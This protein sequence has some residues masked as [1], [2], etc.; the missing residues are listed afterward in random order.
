MRLFEA[1]KSSVTV[2]EAAQCYGIAVRRGMCRCPFHSDKTPSAKADERFHCF[3]CG[4]DYSVIDFTANLFGIPPVDAAKKLAYDFGIPYDDA[5]NYR[6]TREEIIR[7]NEIRKQRKN[8]ERFDALVKRCFL[9]LLD[10]Y[11][12]MLEWRKKYAPKQ[13]ADK[14]HPLFVEALKNMSFAD[15]AMDVLTVGSAA[16][17]SDFIAEFGKGVLELEKRLFQFVEGEAG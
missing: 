15:Y 17:K 14:L 8:A 4:A 5:R 3:G 16:D 12:L 10:Y 6:P 11:R 1:V 2:L 7:Q 13:A 9:I